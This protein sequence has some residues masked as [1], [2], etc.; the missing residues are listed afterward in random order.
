M[1]IPLLG[2]EVYGGTKSMAISL[3][4]T[5]TS[6]NCH[7]QLMQLVSSLERPCLHALTLGLENKSLRANIVTFLFHPPFLFLSRYD[8][9]LPSFL[10]TKIIYNF[11]FLFLSFYFVEFLFLLFFANSCMHNTSTFSKKNFRE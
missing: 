6:S 5:R 4:R 10:F 3:L 9:Y 7:S 1:G 8:F 11:G 2:D